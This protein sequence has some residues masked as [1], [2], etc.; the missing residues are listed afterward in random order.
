MFSEQATSCTSKKHC[1]NQMRQTEKTSSQRLDTSLTKEDDGK[2]I[3]GNYMRISQCHKKG[4][5][6]PQ[7]Q[8]EGKDVKSLKKEK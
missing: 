8:S 6:E 5:R 4:I 3:K 2:Q 1:K 7:K